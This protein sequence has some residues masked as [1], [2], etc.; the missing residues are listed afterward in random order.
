[1]IS[2][3]PT[4]LISSLHSPNSSFL[5][6][7]KSKKKKKNKKNKNKKHTTEIHRYKM[8]SHNI[9]EKKP[10]KTKKFVPKSNEARGLHQYH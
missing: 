4:P 10:S 9:Q 3:L 7:H 5:S 2:S 6:F 1:M 8:N